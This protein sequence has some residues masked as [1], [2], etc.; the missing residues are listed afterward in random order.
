VD[1]PLGSNVLMHTHIRTASPA[2]AQGTEGRAHK[3]GTW[4]AT[5][6]QKSGK[7]CCSSPQHHGGVGLALRIRQLLICVC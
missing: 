1:P 6:E 2:L 5:A 4:E 7:H 3:I